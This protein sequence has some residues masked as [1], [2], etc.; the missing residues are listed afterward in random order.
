MPYVDWNAQLVDI[1]IKHLHGLVNKNFRVVEENLNSYELR[2]DKISI[3]KRKRAYKERSQALMY[4]QRIG[5]L[6]SFLRNKYL[7]EE[8]LFG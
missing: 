8:H 7:S 5:A 1:L 6:E 4:K 3:E 2:N